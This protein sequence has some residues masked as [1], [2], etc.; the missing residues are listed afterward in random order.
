MIYLLLAVLTSTSILIAFN[1]FDR[2][3]VHILPAIIVNYA[4]AAAFGFVQ[5]AGTTSL[6]MIPEKPWFTVSIAAAV[7]LIL[8]FNLFAHSAARVGITI[9]AISARMSVI[10]PVILGFLI[11]NETL[12]A[13]RI[14]GIIMALA[15]FFLTFYSGRE[16]KSVKS[17]YFFLPFFLFLT[18]GANDS[19]LKA[20]QHYYITNDFTLFLAT[21]FLFCLGIGLLVFFLQGKKRT[22]RFTGSTL[23]AG[24]ILGLLNWFSTLFFLKGLSIYDVSVF[25]PL[26]NVSIVGLSALAGSLFFKEKLSKFNILGIGLAIMA[27]LLL[28][29]SGD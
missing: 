17:V 25:V 5:E 12:G 26:L 3:R 10:I 20:A 2:F 21:A 15:A 9:T 19:L 27:I 16:Q 7:L 28:G 1:L 11:F 4:V 6:V 22:G 23:V 18:Q 14:A 8:G 13:L 24:I 29:T